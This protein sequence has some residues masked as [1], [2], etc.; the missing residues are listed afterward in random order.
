MRSVEVYRG[1]ASFR[2]QLCDPC[3]MSKGKRIRQNDESIG[4]RVLGRVESALQVRCVLQFD[5]LS[6]QCEGLGY[7]RQ[8]SKLRC[9]DAAVPKDGDARRCRYDLLEHLQVLSTQLGK[10]K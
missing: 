10:I 3:P 2:G 5:G 7:P 1:Q 9:V 4:V 8:L 6:L